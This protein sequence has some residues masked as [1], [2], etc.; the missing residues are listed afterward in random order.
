MLSRVIA[1]ITI[2][3]AGFFQATFFQAMYD[4]ALRIA[5]AKRAVRVYGL[6][7]FWYVSGPLSAPLERDEVMFGFLYIFHCCTLAWSARFIH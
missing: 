2:V 5:A 4:E 7:V 1:A 3:V 6:C